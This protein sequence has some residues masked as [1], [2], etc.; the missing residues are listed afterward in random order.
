MGILLHHSGDLPADSTYDRWIGVAGAKPNLP[1]SRR[2]SGVAEQLEKAFEETANDWLDL[3]RRMSEKRQGQPSH[4]PTCATNVSD[5]GEM[6]AWGRVCMLNAGVLGTTLII[7]DD[8]WLFRHIANTVPAAAG[9]YPKFGLKQLKLRTR[10]FAARA[11]Y[12]FRAATDSLLLKSHRRDTK[13]GG[14]WL[15]VYGH[16][17]SDATGVDGY[18]GELPK[19]LTHLSRALHVDCARERAV[20]LKGDGR[21]LSLRAWGDVFSA[22]SL[23]FCRWRPAAQFKT[24]PYGWLIQR[25]AILEGGTAQAAAITWQIHCQQAWLAAVSPRI[26]AWPWENHAWE[27][28]LTKQAK[29]VG[30]ATL[31]YQHSVIGRHMLNYEPRSMPDGAAG[32]P[33]T[34]LCTGPS[35]HEQLLA[36]NVPND[37]VC[38]GGALRYPDPS[39]PQYHPDAPV[40]VAL[41][42]DKVIAAEILAAVQEAATPDRQ[43]FV[44]DHPMTPFPLQSKGTVQRASGALE[45]LPAVSSVIY[46]ATTVG[47]EALAGG[48]PT[49]RF[50][51]RSKLSVDILPPGL[52]APTTEHE[53]LAADLDAARPPP[54]VADRSHV[55]AA[56]NIGLWTSR[57]KAT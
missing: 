2:A 23:L 39:C 34:I 51:S 50:R 25:A 45:T 18:F 52:S 57:L 11:A 43:F 55:F 15:L 6:L 42:F 28:V 5:F 22:C 26:V 33:D 7:C 4:V 40:F 21:T 19:R 36:W 3:A 53:S 48:L 46:A 32:L 9:K 29:N 17:R 41:P 14:S 54:R 24:G 8:P 20:T 27:R 12:A 13:N 47:L 38:V 1:L 37:K 56:P 44:R 16:P 31:G 35:T 49:L 30:T 10:G